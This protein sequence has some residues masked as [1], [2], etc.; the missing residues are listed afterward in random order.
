MFWRSFWMSL[1]FVRSSLISLFLSMSFWT[2]CDQELLELSISFL[3]YKLAVLLMICLLYLSHPIPLHQNQIY[4]FTPFIRFHYHRLRKME[5]I[6]KVK[7]IK[8]TQQ[9]T[10]RTQLRNCPPRPLEK[11]NSEFLLWCSFYRPYLCFYF[12]LYLQKILLIHHRTV[13]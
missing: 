7:C 9:T 4:L 12:F 13:F 6:H 10:N 1:I 11:Y 3:A 8:C 2:T 5:D